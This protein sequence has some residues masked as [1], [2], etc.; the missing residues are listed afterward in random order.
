M[1]KLYAIFGGNFDPIH[2]GHIFLAE[3]LA[4][5]V[6]IE[7]IILL[8]NSNPPHKKK[9]KTS[10]AD[11]LNMIKLA[12]RENDLFHISYLET[13]KKK[14]FYTF[15]TLKKIRKKIGYSVSLCFIM[16]EDNWQNF[17]LW[18]N[19]ESILLYCH[20]LICPRTYEKKNHQNL[21]K[22]LNSYVIKDFSLLH[23]NSFGFIFFSNT[24]ILNI[25]SSQIRENYSKGKNSHGLLPSV[26]NKY[27]LL[28]KLYL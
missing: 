27:I 26:V 28:K 13:G 21:K 8:P 10:I 22:L 2:Y 5:E 4:K 9:T 11:K 12:T 23:K 1:K 7:K 19:W 14:I 15:N 17:H 20:I 16:G 6:F 3:K 18:R 24:P 25:S